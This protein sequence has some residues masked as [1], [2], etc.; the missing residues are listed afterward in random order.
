MDIGISGPSSNVV[1]SDNWPSKRLRRIGGQPHI[2][3]VVGENFKPVEK[4]NSNRNG[5]AG[6]EKTRKSRSIDTRR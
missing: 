2:D 6:T 1:T 4:E 3:S 5:A